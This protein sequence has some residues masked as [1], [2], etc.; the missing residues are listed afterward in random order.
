MGPFF[1]ET[2]C[3]VNGWITETVNAHRY[4]TLLRETVVPCLIQRGQ[5]LNV[6][7][8]QDGATSHTANPVKTFLIQTLGED[9]IVSRRCRY[10][11]PPRSPDLTPAEFWLVSE[12]FGK[13]FNDWRNAETKRFIRRPKGH[14]HWLSGQGWNISET[15]EFV[16]CSHAAVVKVYRA[17]QN[18]TVQNQGRGKCGAP[19]AIDDRG[20]RRLR[21]CVRADRRA[22]VEQLTTKMNQGATKSV[23]QTTIQRTLLRLGLRSRR[24][25]RASM[26]TTVHRRRRLEFARQ[27]SSWTSTEWRQVAFSDESR[28]MLHR[29]DGRWRIRRETSE[30]SHPATTAGTVQAGGGSIMVW[31]MFSWHSL[32]SLIIVE[33]TMDQYKYASV[34][35]DHVHPYMRI[36]FPQ[37]DGIFQ[38]DNARCH[39]AAS[40]RA[41]FEEHQDE[42]PVLPWPENSSDLNLIEHL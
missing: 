35:A 12:G 29:T 38:Q 28:F 17:W 15:A 5:I 2:Q 39:T 11:W 24:L 16:N 34:L 40:V 14:D 19:R 31:G 42:F 25:V 33:G 3:P 18:E 26:L 4:L 27:Y 13:H 41:W 9:R 36:A 6:M 32:G 21:R 37:D 1:F 7:F 30:R 10:P 8:M 22:T 20:E 23:S